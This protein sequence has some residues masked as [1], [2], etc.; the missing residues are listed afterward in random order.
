MTH[1]T[2]MNKFQR[3]AAKRGVKP[4]GRDK[5][6][7]AQQTEKATAPAT[8]TSRFGA[9]N[10][11]K[12]RD[13]A[14]ATVT[15]PA[16]VINGRKYTDPKLL[17]AKAAME[18][19]KVDTAHA[20]QVRSRVTVVQNDIAS[21]RALFEGWMATHKAFYPSPFN[22]TNMMRALESVMYQQDRAASVA[23]FDEV[24]TWLHANG[25]LEP[26]QRFRGQPSARVYPEYVLPVTSSHT[27]TGAFIPAGPVIAEPTLPD[28]A[29]AKT[30]NFEEL[31]RLVR[32]GYKPEARQ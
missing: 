18:Q 13:L 30:M 14:P 28:G 19:G 12:A 15:T 11:P 5:S 17:E 21:V 24:F 20:A 8:A 22:L 16:I 3:D 10:L 9:P 25:Y 27:P 23:L 32:A 29:N 26:A 6:W 4:V 31:K 2:E 7:G 1:P